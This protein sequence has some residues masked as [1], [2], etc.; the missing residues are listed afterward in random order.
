MSKVKKTLDCPYCD[1]GK[2]VLI[3]K[4]KRTLYYACRRCYRQLTLEKRDDIV[5]G[6]DNNE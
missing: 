5:K 6:S 3:E 2:M 1:G 4:G